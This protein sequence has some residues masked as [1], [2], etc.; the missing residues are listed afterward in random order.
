MAQDAYSFIS[1][2]VRAAV[3]AVPL[4]FLSV[5]ASAQGPRKPIDVITET[6]VES[7]FV[8]T[9]EGLGTLLANEQVEVTTLITE[10]VSAINF[11]DG[12]RVEADQIL[13]EFAQ[14][15]EAALLSEAQATLNEASSELRRSE[16]LEKRGAVSETE[17]SQR[18]REFGVADAR[19]K[20]IEAQI[21]DR[22]IR[23]P[24]AG[25]VGIRTV[26]VGST[27]SPGD[28]IVR[29]VDD[30]VM[31]LD[32]SVPSTF[33]AD[34][35]VG[36]QVVA[37]SRAFRDSEFTGVVAS[38]DSVVDPV[39]RSVLVR[40]IIPN[41]D[42]LLRPGLLMTVDL[43]F[44]RRGAIALPEEALIPS[45]DKSFVYVVDGAPGEQTAQRRE[46]QIGD[47]RFGEV[48]VLSGLKAGDQVITE[49]AIK[50]RPGA[51]VNPKVSE[52]ATA[53]L[54]GASGG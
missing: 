18:R 50:L 36:E 20:A 40:A 12:D 35:A 7:E 25:R 52:G 42:G 34:L 44:N 43:L 4:L 54:F 23:A 5:E 22:V 39:T 13:V 8:D 38:I 15:E 32:F 28:I 46:I 10:R 21:E 30:T 47:R 45:G 37:R 2:R 33:L 48:E 1:S 9:I 24:F 3:C 19:F 31:K 11:N 27:V 16:Q 49:G 53:E 29:L 6:V 41:P 14:R 51:R 26:S 17:L